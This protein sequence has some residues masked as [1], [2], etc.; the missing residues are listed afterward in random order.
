MA[1]PD[2]DALMDWLRHRP[3]LYREK[4]FVLVHAGLAPQWNVEQAI[5]L[6]REVE[7]AL[8]ADSPNNFLAHLYG[9]QPDN[10]RDDLTGIDR[11]RCIVNYLTRMRF[12]DAEGRLNLD[13]KGDLKNKPD[14]LIPWFELRIG[15]KREVK[16]ILVIG[17]R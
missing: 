1:A 3:L 6:A 12:C 8:Q 15:E 5:E 10:W 13:Y 17:R 4:D 11:L 7:H 9:N 14:D 2:K 16:I